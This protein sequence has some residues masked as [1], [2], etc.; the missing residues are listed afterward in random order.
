ML[1]LLFC[2]C[3]R[4]G[5]WAPPPTHPFFFSILFIASIPFR[6]ISCKMKIQC[7]GSLA[8]HGIFGSVDL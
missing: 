3:F 2:N 1:V 4:V 5:S 6:I 7:F 8:F